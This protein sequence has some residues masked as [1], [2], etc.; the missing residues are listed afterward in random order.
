MSQVSALLDLQKLDLEIAREKKHLDELPEKAAILEVRAKKHEIS[1]LHGKGELLLGKLRK[2]LKAHQDEIFT[3][4]EKIDAEQTKVMETKDHRVVQSITREMDGLRRRRDKVE[5][6]TLGL[7]ERIDKASGQVATIDEALEKLD[8]REAALTERYKTVGHKVQLEIQRLESRRNDVAK[9]LG[10]DLLDRYEGLRKAKGGIGVGK[11]VNGSCSAC[12]M[13][14]PAQRVRAL[15]SGPEVGVCP[16]CMRMI[17]VR[18][19][20]DE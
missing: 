1:E 11:L 13:Q 16:Q 8:V 7:M 19:E 4:T 2:D 5:N 15:E 18:A 12:R 6:E 9:T 10:A 17:I 14:L 3:L 20:D